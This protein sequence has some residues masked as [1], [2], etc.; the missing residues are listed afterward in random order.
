MQL[1]EFWD[2]RISVCVGVSF[3]FPLTQEICE[4]RGFL[5][6]TL[7]RL[8]GDPVEEFA[9]FVVVTLQS[10]FRARKEK[11]KREEVERRVRE[12]QEVYSEKFSSAATSICSQ[13]GLV[14]FSL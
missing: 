2:L 7:P 4:Y 1:P 8:S 13:V 12:D 3:P 10:P 9:M 6:R 14:F 5:P 11:V